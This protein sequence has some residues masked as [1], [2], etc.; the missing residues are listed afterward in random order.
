MNLSMLSTPLLPID[1]IN[2]IA[3]TLSLYLIINYVGKI[4]YFRHI[5]NGLKWIGENSMAV[6]MVHCVEYQTLIPV[7]L[8]NTKLLIEMASMTI[9][10]GMI[11]LI[12]PIVNITVCIFLVMLWQQVK[13]IMRRY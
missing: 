2:A 9:I 8:K 4:K 13:R 5:K 10:K 6:F 3:L 1:T 7:M 12:T 11:L